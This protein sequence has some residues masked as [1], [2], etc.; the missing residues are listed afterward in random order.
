MRERKDFAGAIG[1]LAMILIAISTVPWIMPKQY[2]GEHKR[3]TKQ[4]LQD[5][6]LID[7]C[8]ILSD[9]Y[10]MLHASPCHDRHASSRFLYLNIE[11]HHFYSL[12]LDVRPHLQG[13]QVMLELLW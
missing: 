1:G 9:S 8:S 5:M 11:Y 13:S 2:E 4:S 6:P 12:H 3:R 10:H 7:S